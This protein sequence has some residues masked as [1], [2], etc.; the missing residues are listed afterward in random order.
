MTVFS[1]SGSGTK[2]SLRRTTWPYRGSGSTAGTLGAGGPYSTFDV[3][4]VA[5]CFTGWTLFGIREMDP[6]FVF[7]KGLH[8]R[9]DKVVM[10]VPIRAGG[11]EEGEQVL[12][13]L[14]NDPATARSISRTWPKTPVRGLGPR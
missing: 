12:S 14:A 5:R 9:D 3:S 7:E 11:K 4:E 6:R 8:D 13:L 1:I 10:D 2:K